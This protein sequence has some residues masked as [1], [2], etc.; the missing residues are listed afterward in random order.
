M[1]KRPVELIPEVRKDV[2]SGIQLKSV[3][4]RLAKQHNLTPAAIQQAYYRHQ[5]EEA[6]VIKPNGHCLLLLQQERALR[7]LLVTCSHGNSPLS[8]SDITIVIKEAYGLEPHR[9]WV[10]DFISRYG[11]EL[12]LRHPK[13]LEDKRRVDDLLG[14]GEGF[15]RAVETT[16]HSFPLRPHNTMNVDEHRVSLNAQGLMFKR[17]EVKSRVCIHFGLCHF[18]DELSHTHHTR[19]KS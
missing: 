2:K 3:V 11:D 6:D 7:F 8:A 14:I 5:H 17:I 10:Y 16:L 15:I 9:Q 4:Q 19:L 13:A 1:S 12:S 18:Y